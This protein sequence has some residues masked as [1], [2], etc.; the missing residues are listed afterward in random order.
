LFTYLISVLYSGVNDHACRNLV[1][2]VR[3]VSSSAWFSE[4]E[5]QAMKYGIAH[6]GSGQWTLILND[7]IIRN[8]FHASRT[9]QSLS[10]KWKKVC[11]DDAFLFVTKEPWLTLHQK[12]QHK[13]GRVRWTDIQYFNY[14]RDLL[15][16]GEAYMYTAFIPKSNAKWPTS[17][18]NQCKNE[19]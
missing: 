1:S 12:I 16:S 19:F 7:P 9:Q 13:S 10:D 14:Y 5:L 11:N 8:L 4:I 17:F 6:Y 18:C 15:S 2:P 3:N